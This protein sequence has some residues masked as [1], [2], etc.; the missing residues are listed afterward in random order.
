M[1]VR[2]RKMEF[3]PN[4]RIIVVSD[5]HNCANLL[6]ALLEKVNYNLKDY[7]IIDGDFVEKGQH[8]SLDTLHYIMD[9]DKSAGVNILAVLGNCDDVWLM[10]DKTKA[11]LVYMEYLLNNPHSLVKEM[12]DKIGLKITR[13]SNAKE[14]SETLKQFFPK[15][16]EYLQ[17]IPHVIESKDYIF[18]HGG[19]YP[20]L[21]NYAEDAHDVMKFDNFEAKGFVFDKWVIVGHWPVCNYC[22]TILNYNPRINFEQKIISIDGGNVIKSSG[23]LNA[24]IIDQGQFSSAYVDNLDTKT[25][26]K[27][28]TGDAKRE[29]FSINWADNSIDILED[30]GEFKKIR[31]KSTQKEIKVLSSCIFEMNNGYHCIDSTTYHLTVKKG[32]EVGIIYKGLRYSMVKY[33]GMVGWI[34]NDAYLLDIPDITSERLIIR[35]VVENDIN[36]LVRW[37]NYP[38]IMKHVGFKD[39]LKTTYAQECE[40]FKDELLDANTHRKS[41]RFMIVLKHSLL[42][43]GEIS[44]NDYNPAKKTIGFGIK[45]GEEDMHRH[46]YGR[47]ALIAFMN[48]LF[49]EFEVDQIISDTLSTNQRAIKFYQSIGFDTSEIKTN[50]WKDPEGNWR[51]AVIIKIRRKDIK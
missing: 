41:R 20:N 50:V 11:D 38:Q 45:I 19:I 22:K 4:R 15:E 7:L 1:E 12:C 49:D 8:S 27:D 9:L 51:D 36:T 47:E 42:P 46:G 40:K 14:V 43:I 28:Y 48:Y 16:W 10:M 26:I 37:W 29:P 30:Y 6:N 31:H 44:Y 13:E 21:P 5:I 25:I 18:V 23:Q 2:I 33:N 34:R 39:G 3:D 17:A 32:D 24:L 35:P